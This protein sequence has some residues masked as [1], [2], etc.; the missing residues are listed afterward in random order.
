MDPGDILAAIKEDVNV[1]VDAAHKALKRNGGK[2]WASRSGAHHVKYLRVIASKIVEKKYELAKLEAINCGKPLEEAAWDMDDVAGCFDYNVDLAEELD[3]KQ[4]ASVSL[5]MLI[6]PSAS[7]FHVKKKET[8]CSLES[9]ASSSLLRWKKKFIKH[10]QMVK[11]I[12]V[13]NVQ[14]KAHIS[15]LNLHVEAQAREYKQTFKA[16]EAMAVAEQVKSDVF[17]SHISKSPSKKLEKNGSRTRGSG[18]P[19][20]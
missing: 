7:P 3:R 4:N 17:V 18:S 12:E 2:E 6:F 14:H 10:R 20:K 16:L 13:Q 11:L 8:E 9:D 1:A 19:F 15:E 5:P